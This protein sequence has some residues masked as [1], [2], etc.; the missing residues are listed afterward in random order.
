MMV[1]PNLVEKW[2]QDLKTFCELYLEGRYPITQLSASK[3]VLTDP[4][5]LRYGVARHSVELMKLLDDPSRER[6]HLIFLAQGAMGRRQKDIWVRL[7]LIAEALHRH[8]R[9]RAARLIKVKQHIHRFL[10]TAG[11]PL[12]S[13]SGYRPSRGAVFA[14]PPSG[15]RKK[16]TRYRYGMQWRILTGDRCTRPRRCKPPRPARLRTRHAGMPAGLIIQVRG[17]FPRGN[18]GR[19]PCSS[20]SGVLC[21]ILR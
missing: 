5:A 12:E 1:P 19:F 21:G 17:L 6:C 16:S 7:A 8:A 3:R 13:P 11:W 20:F 9:G 4:S 2:E 15:A 14:G 18:F 10:E